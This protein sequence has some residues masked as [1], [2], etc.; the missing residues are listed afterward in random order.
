MTSVLHAPALQSAEVVGAHVRLS[1]S[2]GAVSTLLSLWLRDNAPELLH[3]STQHRVVETSS[4]PADVHPAE[5]T[6]GDDGALHITWAHDDHRS[7]YPAAWLA[8]HDYSNGA[9]HH[10]PAITLWDSGALDDVP[11]AS[12]P[13]LL[14]DNAMRRSFLH[15]FCAYGVALLR[16]V[17]TE[18]GSVLQVA[19]EFGIVRPTSWGT[20][21][22]VVSM[23]DANSVAYT[24]LPLVVHTD[25]GYRDP[26]PTVQLQHFL[27]S[28]TSG[29]MATLTDGYKVAADLRAAQPAL[30]HLLAAHSLQFHFADATAEHS[31][32]GPVITLGPEGD[33]RA[34]RYSNHSA[35]PFL[36]PPDVMADYYEAYRTFGTMRESQQY[37]LR[38]DMQAGEL[39]MVDN[40][41]VMHGRTGFSGGG[42]RHLQ[43][44]YIERDE[45]VSRLTVLERTMG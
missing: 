40:R 11:R 45:L 41:R 5:C 20:V 12:W 1:W 30:F 35:R 44:C 17:P 2:D 13:E 31:A 21:F 33:V 28:D 43:S 32:S 19:A 26:A 36:L 9:R 22:D 15:G 6:V 7:V 34:I 18:P 37:Q 29:G 14:A 25:E 42:A 3:T 38:I 27:R 23:I 24:N 4:I 16:D 8:A 10:Q 39:Y